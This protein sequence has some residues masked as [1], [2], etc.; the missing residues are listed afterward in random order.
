[1]LREFREAVDYIRKTAWPSRN[2]GETVQ[3]G[4]SNG[5]SAC[6]LWSASAAGRQLYDGATVR[7]ENHAISSE[8]SEIEDLF[9][10]IDAFTKN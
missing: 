8:A 7:P 6:S 10:A 5:N 4:Y 9:H 3:S 2:A 1:V